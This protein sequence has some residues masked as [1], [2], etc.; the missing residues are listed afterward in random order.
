MTTITTTCAGCG[1]TLA[2]PERYLGRDLK[3]PDCGRPFRVAPPEPPP[4]E[5]EP[6]APAPVFPEPSAPGPGEPG[7]PPFE[8]ALA[9][10]PSDGA[11]PTGT[12]YW[13]VRRVGVLSAA[14]TSAVIHASF[15]L[16]LG[17]IV[18]VVSLVLP[19]TA[20]PFLR[21]RVLGVLA[22]VAL[23]LVYGVVGFV[24]GALGAAVYNLAARLAGGIKLALE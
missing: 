12:V 23:P 6:P 17:V 21:G 11:V 5:P 9:T 1:R 16:L 7:A 14:A 3:C 19:G 13:R 4:P 22:V 20:V 2:I 24:A 18:A 10:A 8:E 15:G